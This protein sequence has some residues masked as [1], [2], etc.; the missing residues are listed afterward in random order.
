MPHSRIPRPE[1]RAPMSP[2]SEQLVELL[3]RLAPADREVVLA[4]V[5][6]TRPPP[7]A[8]ASSLDL[9]IDVVREELPPR[10]ST[11]PPPPPA[12]RARGPRIPQAPA[13]PRMDA[14][15]MAREVTLDL[16]A[17]DT[18]VACGS[19][20]V[21]T[22]LRILPSTAGLLL[23]WDCEDGDFTV[24]YATGP[25][26]TRIVLTSG[27]ADDHAIARAARAGGPVTIVYG[28]CVPMLARHA[29]FGRPRGAHIIP[30]LD[31]GRCLGSIELVEPSL[32]LSDFTRV[33]QALAYIATRFAERVRQ[34][35]IVLSNIV[36]PPV[37]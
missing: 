33:Q 25:R 17:L 10:R 27:T 1:R 13:V 35:G 37:G 7:P 36:P 5:R 24:A 32:P 6:D 31:Q 12:V 19:L 3:L 21:A 2:E 16:S 26:A 18:A 9:E 28:N 11:Q 8:R 4:R 30:V 23:L 14:M 29:H 22:A 15:A 20:C 34:T